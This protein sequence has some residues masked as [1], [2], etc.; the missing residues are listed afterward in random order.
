MSK[1]RTFGPYSPSRVVSDWCY[2]SGQVGVDPGTGHA[3]T[4]VQE[5]TE[6]ALKNLEQV[7]VEAGFSMRDVVKTTIYLSAMDNFS[8][9]NE[10]YARAFSDP[11]PARSTVAV[12]ELPRVSKNGVSVKVEIEAVAHRGEAV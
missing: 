4:S 6:R 10:V 8:V 12:R 11:F 9:V 2:V 3:A 5:Q 1:A 7:L